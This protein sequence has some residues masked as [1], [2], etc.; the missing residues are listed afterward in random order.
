[1]TGSDIRKLFLDYFAENGHRVCPS[2]SLV[3]ANDPTLLFT[4]AGMNQFKDV[5]TGAEQRDYKRATTSQKCLRVSGKHNDLE[6]VGRTA[7]HHTFFEMLGN[8]SFGDYFKHDAIIFCWEFLVDRVGID[9]DKLWVS[10]YED[11]DEAGELWKKLTPVP[12]ERIIK[13][14]AK[15]NF[16]SMGDTGPCGPCSEI[17]FDQGP[18]IYPCPDEDSCG[19]ECDCDRYLELWNLVFMQFDRDSSGT[20]NPLPKP[21]IDTGMGLERVTAVSQGVKTNYDTDLFLPIINFTAKLAGVEYGAKDESDVSLRVIADHIRAATFLIADGV[22]PSNEGRGYVLRRVMRRALRH[23]RL[24]GFQGDFFH[25]VAAT[26]IDIME[27]N[28]SELADKRDYIAKV[29]F[30]EEERFIRTLD[31]GLQLLEAEVEKVVD[32]GEKVLSGDVIF[33]LYDTFGFPVDL[34]EDIVRD[35]GITLDEAGFESAMNKQREKARS[36]WKGSGDEGVGKLYHAMRDTAGEAEFVGYHTLSAKTSIAALAVDGAPADSAG[37]GAKVEIV[38]K[39]TPFY[40]ESGGQMGDAGTLECLTG[41]VRVDEAAK[42]LGDLTVLRGVVT[43]GQITQGDEIEAR[44]ESG[45]RFSTMQNHSAT[46]LLQAALQKVLG[47]H[48]NQ[49]G[50]LVGPDRMRFDFTHFAAMTGE[51]LRRV[52]ELVNGWIME[53]YSVSV[54]EEDYEKAVSTGVM[55]LFGEKYESD[56]RVVRMGEVSAELCGGTHAKATGDIGFFKL[57]SEAGVAAGVRRIEGATGKRALQRMW[58]MED[59]LQEIGKLTKASPEQAVDR[60]KRLQDSVKELEREVTSLR[61]K[62]AG[63]QSS[64][65]LS[66]AREIA[67]VKVLAA[68]APISD[69]KGLREFADSLRDRL[70]SGVF[71]LGTEADGKAVLL[72]GVTADLTDRLKAGALIKEIAA[73]VGG[74]GGGR[75]DMA[76]A[77]GPDGSKLDAALEAFYGEVEKMLG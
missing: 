17:H 28:F 43:K 37:E 54:S 30:H 62:L 57:I 4:N 73:V 51:E 14:G 34:T 69:P 39:K 52:E 56:V 19:P 13:C 22:L 6:N 64:D 55:A 12:P 77:G 32:A 75:P 61:G 10:I 11:D 16:W 58:A 26:V 50:S 31:R 9:P 7:R 1:M 38:L 24:L 66:E 47:G 74:K 23:G 40:G 44:V 46:H 63:G 18:G 48:V 45:A 68:R 27:G 42:P 21:S 53:N 60:V 59:Q 5:F 65:I 41:A 20:L 49:A 3:P 70:K 29:I 67:G 15:D 2:S 72:V 35:R 76:Q 36:A 8:F 25:K 33:R 71:A